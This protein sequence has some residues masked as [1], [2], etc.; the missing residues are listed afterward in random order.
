VAGGCPCLCRGAAKQELPDGKKGIQQIA[1]ETGGRF[2]RGD[3]PAF[4]RSDFRRI[5]EDLR[6]SCNIGYTPDPCRPAGPISPPPFDSPPPRPAKNLE[7]SDRA[8]T[9]ATGLTYASAR[10]AKVVRWPMGRDGSGTR[11][12]QPGNGY[13]PAK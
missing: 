1:R 12:T 8:Q 9:P 7:G 11:L 2:L 5:E 3:V 4:A 13:V 6:T 10:R